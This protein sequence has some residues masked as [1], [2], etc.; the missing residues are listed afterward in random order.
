MGSSGSERSEEKRQKTVSLIIAA[1]CIYLAFDI[2]YQ[3]IDDSFE[4]PMAFAIDITL[5]VAWLGLA[6]MKLTKE[7]KTD[8]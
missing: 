8:E 1:L 6:A 3:A 4:S 7:R 2:A 5:A